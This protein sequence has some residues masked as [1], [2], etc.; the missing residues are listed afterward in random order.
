MHT[1]FLG[2]FVWDICTFAPMNITAFIESG[3]ITNYCLGFCTPEEIT[4]VETLAAKHPEIKNE[5]EKIH[6][7]FEEH[8]LINAIPPSPSVK[9]AIMQTVYKQQAGVNTKY[10]PLIDKNITVGE[11]EKWI[12]A[13]NIRPPVEDFE[14]LFITE[15]PSTKEVINFIVSA[16]NGHE[17]E[18]HPD[19]IE[20]LFVIQGSCTMDFD[21]AKRSYNAGE[22]IAIPPNVIHSAVVTSVEPMLAIVQ[23][24]TI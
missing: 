14:N 20:Y 2:I 3:I 11:L 8:L 21:G 1:T 10:V 23:R 6:I 9:I 17:P 4:N 16:K 24:Q 7:H 19:F 18:V 15:L 12:I 13:N 22:V 5:I